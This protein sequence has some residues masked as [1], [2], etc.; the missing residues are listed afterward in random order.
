MDTYL[1]SMRV[2]APTV[3]S[4]FVAMTDARSLVRELMTPRQRYDFVHALTRAKLGPSYA[5]GTAY[6]PD[7][8]WSAQRN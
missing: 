4:H 3:P 2:L 7:A 5:P 6:Q 1:E 8:T